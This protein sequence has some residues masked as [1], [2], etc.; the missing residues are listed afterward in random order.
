MT[1]AQNSLSHRV[2]HA[3]ATT[4]SHRLQGHR[5]AAAAGSTAREFHKRAARMVADGLISREKIKDAGHSYFWY[6]LNEMQLAKYRLTA[7]M[8]NIDQMAG[9]ALVVD[10]LDLPGRLTFLRML[11]EQT[12]FHDHAVLAAI[13]SDYERTARLRRAVEHHHTGI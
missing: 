5:L 4:P 6:S 10:D 12:V 2:Q 11:R 8:T 9:A 13:I 7:A 3:L 1:P